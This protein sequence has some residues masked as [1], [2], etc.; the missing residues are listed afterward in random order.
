MKENE[1]S[2]LIDVLIF[3]TIY[4]EVFYVLKVISNKIILN[5]VNYD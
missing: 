2:N 1:F 4:V 3:I 5:F